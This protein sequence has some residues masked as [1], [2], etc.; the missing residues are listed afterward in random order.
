M[1]FQLINKKAMKKISISLACLFLAILS[2][3]QTVSNTSISCLNKADAEKILGQ[4]ATL[5]ENTTEEKDNAVKYRCTY[6]ATKSEATTGKTG[7]LYYMFEKYVS[8]ASA[9]VVYA[10]ILAQ[11]RNMPNFKTLNSIG[12]EALRHTDNENFDMIIVRKDDKILR[13]KVNKLTALTSIKNLQ[14]IAEEITAKL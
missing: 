2:C 6:T 12:D 14:I 8:Q 10:G 4:P 13:L 3:G 1:H 7:H 11:N 5:T 9:K